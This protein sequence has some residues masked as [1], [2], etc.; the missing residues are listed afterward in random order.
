MNCT[1]V[2]DELC[3]MRSCQNIKALDMPANEI[4]HCQ[5]MKKK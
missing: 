1:V 5:K 3:K 4:A 2:K